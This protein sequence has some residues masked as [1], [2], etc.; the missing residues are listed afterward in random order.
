MVDFDLDNLPRS[1]DIMRWVDP[2][3]RE[4]V[5]I[6]TGDPQ[7]DNTLNSLVQ[8]IEEL[9]QIQKDLVAGRS[10][11]EGEFGII[12]GG[13]P[14][15]DFRLMVPHTACSLLMVDLIDRINKIAE[16]TIGGSVIQN[17]YAPFRR[18]K[19]LPTSF[20]I[21]G[22]SLDDLFSERQGEFRNHSLGRYFDFS[23]SLLLC[24]FDDSVARKI[25]L[26]TQEDHPDLEIGICE[27]S[28]KA[29]SGVVNGIIFSEGFRAKSLPSGSEKM[30]IAV[31]DRS[32]KM[33]GV[34]DWFRARTLAALLNPDD[35]NHQDVRE[36]VQTYLPG[37][38]GLDLGLMHFLTNGT[39]FSANLM[40]R[41]AEQLV[42][43]GVS[44]DFFGE[45]SRFARERTD[46]D[47]KSDHLAISDFRIKELV[48]MEEAHEVVGIDQVVDQA[49]RVKKLYR[50]K[51]NCVFEKGELTYAEFERPFA[52]HLFIDPT[53]PAKMISAEFKFF[54]D[55][56][57][58][59]ATLLV[60]ICQNARSELERFDWSALPDPNQMPELRDFLMW[61]I[62]DAFKRSEGI[63][64]EQALVREA[65]KAKKKNV[66][67][68][69]TRR[70]PLAFGEV[71]PRAVPREKEPARPMVAAEGR[72]IRR[73]GLSN[74]QRE[75]VEAVS[76]R[77]NAGSCNL[78]RLSIP[79]IRGD[80]FF[81]VFE[82]KTVVYQRIAKNTYVPAAVGSMSEV[83]KKLGRR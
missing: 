45:V 64:K 51:N 55:R 38:P 25:T 42:R 80:Y 1:R 47:L 18:G 68:N 50:D 78:Q 27:N 15:E 20:S 77:V 10:E 37:G 6:T 41:R 62:L 39:R 76:R 3:V 60:K 9:M 75:L 28:A 67:P 49:R 21:G 53:N 65:E 7:A 2:N 83:L 57:E 36:V 11:K 82:G 22:V 73:L 79:G 13:D 56:D 72:D 74:E 34:M 12:R 26:Q 54:D 40:F 29:V 70:E 19:T 58:E 31:V 33:V 43:R 48:A 32:N 46:E 4:Q 44:V 71:K 23:L 30:R 16:V 63:L 61:V 17:F 14:I 66:G 59:E 5:I 35:S 24:Q 8:K 81:S 52:V 69:V